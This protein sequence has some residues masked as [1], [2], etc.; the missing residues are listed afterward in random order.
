MAMT[1]G[2]SSSIRTR[3]WVI[4]RLDDWRD[5]LSLVFY[6]FLIIKHKHPTNVRFYEA[7]PFVLSGLLFCFRDVEDQD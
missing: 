2:L 7:S 6:I 5:Y 3:R 4:S 1:A